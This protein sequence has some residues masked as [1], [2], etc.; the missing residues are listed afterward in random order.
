[1]TACQWRVPHLSQGTVSMTEKIK[2][3]TYPAP[4][5]RVTTELVEN[6]DA[7]I[8]D[9]VRKMAETMYAAPGVGLAANQVGESKRILVYDVSPSGE[10]RNLS[11][12]INPKIVLMEGEVVQEEACLSVVDFSAEVSRKAQIKV[13]G[14]DIDGNPVDIEAEGLLAR[15]LQHE[16]DHLNG[17]L[18]IDHISSLK[19]ALY[20]KRLKKM[21]K[22]KQ[23]TKNS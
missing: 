15:C 19:R 20:N 10:G 1:M 9:L 5:L 7:E 14:V 12:I 6:I 22:Q 13:Q 17:I 3:Y 2:I 16:I 11:V 4:I 23:S 18:F 8:H 21:L